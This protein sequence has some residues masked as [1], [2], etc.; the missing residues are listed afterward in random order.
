MRAET[1]DLL[2]ALK[3]DLD[4]AEVPNAATIVRESNIAELDR[5]KIAPHALEL[6]A[7]TGRLDAERAER[8]QRILT[9]RT[10]LASEAAAIAGLADGV[11]ARCLFLRG[12]G[13]QHHYPA[14]YV[15][16]FN[17]LDVA[18]ATEPELVHLLHVLE[19]RGYYASRLP[20]LR[21]NLSGRGG[22]R[23]LILGLNRRTDEL[24]EPI[25]LDLYVG[26]P[27]ITRQTHLWL[28]EELFDTPSIALAEGA[29]LPVL[30]ATWNF[31]SLLAECFE[32]ER[33]LVRDL[34]DFDR[35]VHAG[36][37]WVEA[38]AEA[39][40]MSLSGQA[41]RVAAALAASRLD[42]AA[43]QVSS[44]FGTGA[45][46]PVHLI[47]GHLLTRLRRES[48]AR[49]PIRLGYVAVE[50][51]LERVETAWPELALGLVRRLDARTAYDLGLSTYLV[52]AATQRQTMRVLEREWNPR[53]RPLVDESELEEATW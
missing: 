34:L 45:A 29:A 6:A 25:I 48:A 19:Q 36:V 11:G 38:T 31:V 44:A 35:I 18:V 50:P 28:P 3:R 42:D 52:R 15:R 43:A 37:D 26:G 27:S 10:V 23:W 8:R 53:L 39:E 13:L 22:E 16:Q 46:R 7:R 4:G 41:R 33:L 30:N 9:K 14:G 20:V 40:R 12:F 5:E 21:R 2:H 32:R 47:L 49:A 24:D 51:V 17:D 1:T